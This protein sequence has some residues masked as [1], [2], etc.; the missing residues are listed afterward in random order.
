MGS[1]ALPPR[2][3]DVHD[4]GLSLCVTREISTAEGVDGSLGDA[5]G[6]LPIDG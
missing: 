2:R 1:L 5:S 3:Q 6:G 4:S